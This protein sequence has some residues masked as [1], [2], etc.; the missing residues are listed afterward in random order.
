MTFLLAILFQSAL[1]FVLGYGI[2][3]RRLGACILENQDAPGWLQWSE[4]LYVALIPRV[5]RGF[6]DKRAMKGRR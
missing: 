3:V 2:A 6:I 4:L 1:C 5:L